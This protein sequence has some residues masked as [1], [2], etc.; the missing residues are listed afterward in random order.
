MQS[1]FWRREKRIWRSET[2]FQVLRFV[3]GFPRCI[4]GVEELGIIDVDI[5]GCYANDL[6]LL[7]GALRIDDIPYRSIFLVKFL[8]L[9]SILATTS[10]EKI[11]VSL[12]PASC[13]SEFWSWNIPKWTEQQPTNRIGD[14]E[15]EKNDNCD[16][17]PSHHG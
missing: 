6:I 1:M 17:Y 3:E 11:I 4:D 15:R 13:C 16:R 8:D 14:N 10:L 9:E 2:P 7:A 5:S 12:V